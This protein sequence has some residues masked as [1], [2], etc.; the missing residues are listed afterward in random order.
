MRRAQS[1]CGSPV[2]PLVCKTVFEVSG[3]HAVFLRAV[4]DERE[5]WELLAERGERTR[6]RLAETRAC[7]ARVDCTVRSSVHRQQEAPQRASDGLGAG[8]GGGGVATGVHT[9]EWEKSLRDGVCIASERERK[10]GEGERR[11]YT[12]TG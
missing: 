8:Q 9:V 1:A 6:I 5:M 12:R 3:R 11:L 2:R 7:G 4:V 10:K